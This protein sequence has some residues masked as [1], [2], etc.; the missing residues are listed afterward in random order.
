[1]AMPDHRVSMNSRISLPW[2]Y[3]GE[4]RGQPPASR[5]SLGPH[6]TGL[7]QASSIET[8]SRG[9]PLPSGEGLWLKG[10][11]HPGRQR[12]SLHRFFRSY[13]AFVAVTEDDAPIDE[14]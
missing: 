8:A 9:P 3:S 6:P 14:P 1:M 11:I 5:D 12:W 2:A 4:S 10:S 7:R 13:R